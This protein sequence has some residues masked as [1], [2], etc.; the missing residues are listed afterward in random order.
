METAVILSVAFFA[1]LLTLISGFGLGTLLLPAFLIFFSPMEAVAMTAVVHF[2]NNVFKFGLLYKDVD[3][4]VLFRFGLPALV[5]AFG[6]AQVLLSMEA[7]HAYSIFGNHVD[8]ITTVI[9]LML[10]VFACME[11]LPTMK[12]LSP[13]T[14]KLMF[15]GLISGFFGG[16][17]GHQGALRSMFLISLNWSKAAYIATGTA[18]A[19]LVDLTRIPLYLTRVTAI[20]NRAHLQLI[21]L[22]CLCAFAG[23]WLGKKL[24]PK[25]TY[26]AVRWIVAICMLAM[27]SAMIFGW[28]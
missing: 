17:S 23:A 26:N 19:L 9:G 12:T 18:V 8:L 22:A 5:A 24:I 28:I 11:L 6:G 27:G 4:K 15:G 20:D 25:I 3:R 7:V 13:S 16:L 2:A 10:M 14:S 21:V 1:S